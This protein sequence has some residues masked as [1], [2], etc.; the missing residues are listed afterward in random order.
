M[1]LIIVTTCKPFIDDAKLIQTQ[2]I[3]SWIKLK[4]IEVK[5]IILGNEEGVKDI[6]DK[7][8]LIQ[9]INFRKFHIFPYI[10][11]MLNCAYNYANDND[12][13][14]WTNSDII[15]MQNLIDT[16]LEFKK[17]KI[18]D[19]VLVGQRLDWKNYNKIDLNDNKDIINIIKESS[20]HTPCGIDYFIHSKNSLRHI[21]LNLSMPAIIADQKILGTVLKNNIYT[22]DCTNTI[23]AIH[24]DCGTQNRE[25]ELFKL[26]EK[27][28]ANIKSSWGNIKQCKN[29]SYYDNN[30]V[31]FKKQKNIQW[32]KNRKNKKFKNKMLKL[33]N[34]I[35]ENLIQKFL[36]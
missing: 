34:N 18:K 9:K 30:I 4:N 29:I 36:F 5:I 17:Q 33:E 12:I 28:N 26:V 15:Y 20:Y 35:K 10:S 2:S 31:K 22:C 13:V 1:K 3:E 16:I 27:N 14:M 21:D 7:Y 24:H 23:L 25:S 19:Y 32:L 6:C 8:N 11:S